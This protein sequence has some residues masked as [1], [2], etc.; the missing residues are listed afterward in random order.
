[1][2]SKKKETI[3]LLRHTLCEMSEHW[4][5]ENSKSFQ[6]EK[7][8]PLWGKRMQ[9]ALDFKFKTTDANMQ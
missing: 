7:I 3:L 2:P 9:L 1:M 5:S 8:S 4:E 6:R